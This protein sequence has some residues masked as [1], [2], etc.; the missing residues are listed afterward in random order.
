MVTCPSWTC[1]ESDINLQKLTTSD[2]LA[3]LVG[4][5]DDDFSFPLCNNLKNMTDKYLTIS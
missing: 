2:Q 3:Q 1:Y 4:D 5:R